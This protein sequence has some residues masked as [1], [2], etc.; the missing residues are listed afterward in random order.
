MFKKSNRNFK[1]KRVDLSDEEDKES[2]SETAIHS[3]TTAE[4]KPVDKQPVV[5]K[6][7]ITCLDE[8]DEEDSQSEFKVKKSKESRRIAREFKKSKKPDKPAQQHAQQLDTSVEEIKNDE[9]EGVRFKPLVAKKPESVSIS[10]YL[11]SKYGH[12][13]N[14]DE[15]EDEFKQ[16][17]E[18]EKEKRKSSS[19]SHS[20]DMNQQDN[21]DDKL[22]VNSLVLTRYRPQMLCVIF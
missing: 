15:E 19:S 8:P 22:E 16:F 9:I 5:I 17:R 13:I 1:A 7:K 6:P 14:D 3:A 20:E 18:E 11:K 21:E 4:F 10:K 2:S 12:I